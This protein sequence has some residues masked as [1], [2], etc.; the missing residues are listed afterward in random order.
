[1]CTAV[2]NNAAKWQYFLEH[3]AKFRCDKKIKAIKDAIKENG[4][5]TL[6]TT[7]C[8]TCTVSL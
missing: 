1:M 8:G 5:A 6:N 7:S 4:A 2:G 3:A